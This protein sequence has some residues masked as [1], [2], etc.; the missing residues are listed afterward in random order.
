MHFIFIGCMI[1]VEAPL[2]VDHR[3]AHI[4]IWLDA[5]NKIGTCCT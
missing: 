4:F 3:R 5:V 2:T 1:L